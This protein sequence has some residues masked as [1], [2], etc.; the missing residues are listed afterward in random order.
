[1]AVLVVRTSG[2]R[3]LSLDMEHQA[4]MQAIEEGYPRRA[5]GV[6][7]FGLPLDDTSENALHS[8]YPTFYGDICEISGRYVQ[9]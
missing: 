2:A 9:G 7:C 8:K 5:P 6:H 3:D 1:V 4:P